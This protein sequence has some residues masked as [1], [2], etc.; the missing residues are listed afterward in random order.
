M[1]YYVL[2]SLQIISQKLDW[3]LDGQIFVITLLFPSHFSTYCYK[4]LG[5]LSSYLFFLITLLVLSSQA[6]F[7]H[8][9]SFLTLFKINK[10]ARNENQN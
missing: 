8:N 10:L 7:C 1:I 3:N 4:Y 6:N 5:C 2:R 9:F